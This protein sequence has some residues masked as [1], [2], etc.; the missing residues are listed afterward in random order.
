M[1]SFG[2]CFKIK[3]SL[4]DFSV[5]VLSFA[6][7]MYLGFSFAH[8]LAILSIAIF[9]TSDFEMLFPKIVSGRFISLTNL[10]DS[11]ELCFFFRLKIPN[12]FSST[13]V[14]FLLLNHH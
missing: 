4:P 11:A 9:I 6:F 8:W 12:Y 2:W 5:T 3:D 1:T 13:V 14:K 10:K 7:F